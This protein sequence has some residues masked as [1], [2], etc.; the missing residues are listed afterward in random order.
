MARFLWHRA[1]FVGASALALA[2]LS[3]FPGSASAVGLGPMVNRETTITIVSAMTSVSCWSSS[4]C[5]AVGWYAQSRS[6]GTVTI[7]TSSSPGLGLVYRTTDGG[8]SWK[9]VNLHVA[10]GELTSVS[11]P[12]ASLCVAVDLEAK[13]GPFSR[14]VISKDAG[15]H[16]TVTKITIPG[17]YFAATAIDCPS[18]S[19]CFTGSGGDRGLAKSTDG[20][21]TW[22]L[23]A[24]FANVN[25]I[26]CPTV[27]VCEVATFD[28]LMLRTTNGGASWTSQFPLPTRKVAYWG[29]SCPTAST[30]GVVTSHGSF[31]RTT[32]GGKK[33]TQHFIGLRVNTLKIAQL[34]IVACTSGSTCEVG[35]FAGEGDW[36]VFETTNGGAIWTLDKIPTMV[37]GL[38]GMECSADGACEMAGEGSVNSP[39]H[40]AIF[41]T[42]DGV[43]WTSQP[44]S[45]PGQ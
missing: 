24:K 21:R 14:A 16:W 17:V 33:W 43:D 13:G 8:T 6:S 36:A 40:T 42:D 12:S 39:S 3:G 1:R 18:S 7:T 27:N 2:V 20:G 35:G 9:R 31:L 34:T 26:A 45:Y 11:C 23:I 4:E 19:I 32:D 25:Q 30:C 28:G 37:S 29:V 15:R 44:V 5:V 38:L 41:K 22:K 10:V